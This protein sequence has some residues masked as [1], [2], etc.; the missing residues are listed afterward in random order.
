MEKRII[1]SYRRK[2]NEIFETDSWFMNDKTFLQ[3]FQMLV[4]V[5]SSVSSNYFYN[6]FI[7]DEITWMNKGILWET[8]I[9][10]WTINA[11]KSIEIIYY[12]HFM[13]RV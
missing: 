3:V 11:T 1:N 8:E 6:L 7:Y 13:W 4:F 2:S 12:N 5:S 10:K 9:T